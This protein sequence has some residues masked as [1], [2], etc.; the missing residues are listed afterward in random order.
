MERREV[1][2]SNAS[3]PG[4][5]TSNLADPLL[6]HDEFKTRGH[7]NTR[8]KYVRYFCE[9]DYTRRRFR[10]FFQD[11]PSYNPNLSLE[12]AGLLAEPPRIRRPWTRRVRET[13][14]VLVL[15]MVYRI[16]FGVPLV[17]QQQ[18]KALVERGYEVI[19]AVPQEDDEFGFP[20]VLTSGVGN[21][22]RKQQYAPS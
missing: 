16:G 11:D 4:C 22:K 7:D 19:V 15:S 5:G 10:H 3:P 20:R 2:P 17:I 14:R 21:C 1:L 9:A 6:V 18:V 12:E 8:E 13:P